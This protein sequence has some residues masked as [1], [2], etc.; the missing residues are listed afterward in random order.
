MRTATIGLVLGALATLPL[1][2]QS[3]TDPNTGVEF[4]TQ[5]VPPAGSES[6]VLTGTGVR[7]RTFL[8]V[9]VYA[10]GLY[11]DP[12]GARGALGSYVAKPAKE[13]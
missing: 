2:A 11:V 8:K 6:H 7:T 4:P 5:L 1:S 12:A 13:L 9:K 3:Y 10:F